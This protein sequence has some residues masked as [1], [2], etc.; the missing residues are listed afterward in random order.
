MI[1][2]VAFQLREANLMCS[3]I[4]VRIRYSNRD[5][6]TMQKK[7]A[8]TASDDVLIQYA[9]DLFDKLYHR[10]ILLRLIGVKLSGLVH[11][12]QQINLFQDNIKMIRLYQAMDQMKHRFANPTLIRRA[13]GFSAYE[14]H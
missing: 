14:H 9:H 11:G 3:T 1:E 10:R 7:I 13:T 5:T 12:N 4:S 6:E 2:K 8:F